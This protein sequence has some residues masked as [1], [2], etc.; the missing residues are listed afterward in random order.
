MS[1]IADPGILECNAVSD[2]SKQPSVFTSGTVTNSKTCAQRHFPEYLDPQQQSCE[3]LKTHN[4]S[5]SLITAATSGARN[6]PIT[7]LAE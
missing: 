2:V 1:P 5:F 4:V 3:N 6:I 7:I